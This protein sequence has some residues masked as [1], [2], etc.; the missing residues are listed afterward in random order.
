MRSLDEILIS[1]GTTIFGFWFI[2]EF[3]SFASMNLR[4]HMTTFRLHFIITPL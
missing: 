4:C 1:L 3:V 2:L